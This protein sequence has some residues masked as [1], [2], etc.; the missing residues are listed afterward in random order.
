MRFQRF[1]KKE[2]FALLLFVISGNKVI[3]ADGVRIETTY[4][5]MKGQAHPEFTN[6]RYD[7]LIVL[8]SGNMGC[9]GNL[10]KYMRK[11]TILN[12]RAF[13]DSVK[14]GKL[15]YRLV[16]RNAKNEIDSVYQ[17]DASYN[18]TDKAIN[19]KKNILS[20]VTF[21]KKGEITDRFEFDY[22]EKYKLE[23][24]NP[25]DLEILFRNYT[26]YTYTDRDLYNL[27]SVWIL[28]VGINDYVDVTY[29]N[30]I[31]DAIS[32]T[33]FFDRQYRKKYRNATEKHINR[34]VLLDS[35]AT[36]E[37]ILSALRDIASK[38][39]YNDYF[40]FNFSGQSS[41][42]TKDSVNYTT[43][44]FPFDIKGNQRPLKRD[45]KAPGD[46]YDHMISLQL[47][48]EYVQ[49][50]PAENQLFIS[51]A[52]PSEKF[53]PEFIKALMQS[54]VEVASLLNKNRIII[55]PDKFGWDATMCKDS[56]YQKGP[57]NYLITS[58]PGNLNVYDLFGEVYKADKVVYHL[59]QKEYNCH[60]SE[61]EYFEVFFERR[62]LKEYR[63]MLG[64]SDPVT[65]GLKGKSSQLK[66]ELIEL[67]GKKYALLV[68][69]DQYKAEGWKDLA[70][71][72][73][74]VKAV[75]DILRDLYGFEV[76]VL[77][78]Q[79][80]DTIFSIIGSYYR[81][82]QP[83]DQVVIFFAGHGD[84]D[85]ELLSDGFIVCTDSKPTE[86]DIARNSYISYM[87]L[88]KMINNLSSR[89]VLVMLDVCHGGVFDQ[90][91]FD[92]M[93]RDNPVTTNIANRNVLQLL[94]DKLPL[95]TRKFL[96]SVGAESAFDGYAGRHSPFVNQLLQ[97]LTS[98][99]KDENGIVLLSDIY[100]VLVKSSL[101]ETAT[102]KISPY[103]ADFGNV[104]AFTEFILMPAGGN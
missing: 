60:F 65:R 29:R 23:K 89:Q 73:K 72:V 7:D 22:G 56:T 97:I 100:S 26:V 14:C 4:V 67:T 103:M 10:E 93:K 84:V 36:R 20:L 71:P 13:L 83:N 52:G 25:G 27:A 58:L 21:G 46:V 51:E 35:Q 81:K 31:T 38:A 98:Q 24:Y 54:S 61:V 8:F 70:N 49:Q 62:F 28:S 55:V 39:G 99:A 12:L 11:D 102:L 86:Q 33:D 96:S 44:F 77:E 37:N 57:I 95:R 90:K 1:F 94:K 42:F 88:Q 76:Q 75:A 63:E 18:L 91:A 92:K 41:I 64:T 66:K 40:I 19:L 3:A 45:P 78:N 53:K 32:T 30:C 17:F 9:M 104:D 50:I 87:K 34:Y 79:P 101:N 74:D 15:D 47:L 2:L 16:Y 6:Y 82:V 68:G 69:T 48:Q 59:K 85:E 5:V 80:I 43:Y